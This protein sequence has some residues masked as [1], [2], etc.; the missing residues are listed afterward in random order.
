RGVGVGV[1]FHPGTAVGNETEAKSLKDAKVGLDSL[2][3]IETEV[4]KHVEELLGLFTVEAQVANRGQGKGGRKYQ[5]AALGVQQE[6]EDIRSEL[7]KL[8]RTLSTTNAGI[9]G[10]EHELKE[11][12]LELVQLHAIE[13]VEGAKDKLTGGQVKVDYAT[14][15]IRWDEEGGNAKADK[16]NSASLDGKGG[17]GEG[18]GGG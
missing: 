8:L 13:E 16:T 9:L 3:I 15:R 18:G 1:G 2:R 14:G 7:V 6:V 12:D 17:G 5:A 10:A 4:E 11:K